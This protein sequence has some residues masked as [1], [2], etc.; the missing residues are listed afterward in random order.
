MLPARLSAR[1][2]ALR[3]TSLLHNLGGAAGIQLSLL[4]SGSLSAR[5]LGPENRGYLA[6]LVAQR[7]FNS[8][9]SH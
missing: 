3:E 1:L 8:S 7:W 6:I 4:V 9:C 2:T 5:L